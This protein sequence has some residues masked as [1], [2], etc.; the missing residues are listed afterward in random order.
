LT[1]LRDP[2]PHSCQVQTQCLCGDGTARPH[3]IC[4]RGRPAH[5][6]VP[7][8][9]PTP[10]HRT[11]QPRPHGTAEDSA[12]G[13]SQP[14]ASLVDRRRRRPRFLEPFLSGKDSFFCFCFLQ[15]SCCP[16]APCV[17]S[18]TGTRTRAS[19]RRSGGKGT[20]HAAHFTDHEANSF[21]SCQQTASATCLWQGGLGCVRLCGMAV[22]GGRIWSNLEPGDVFL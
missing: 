4:P 14:R 7:L 9:A 12:S 13:A 5:M 22:S 18:V 2:R 16:V 1:C 20:V 8:P 10:R 6:A 3:R 15:V 19:G 11:M 17:Q 21:A